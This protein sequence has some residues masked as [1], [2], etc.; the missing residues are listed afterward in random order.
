M[1]LRHY[2]GYTACLCRLTTLRL[3]GYKPFVR[4]AFTFPHAIGVTA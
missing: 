3:A 2:H 1:D 4:F